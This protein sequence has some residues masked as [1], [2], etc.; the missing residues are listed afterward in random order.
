V[1]C[2]ILKQVAELVRPRV[3]ALVDAEDLVAVAPQA[4]REVRADLPRGAGDQDS[5]AADSVPA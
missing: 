1:P 5:H 3:L 4:E 2:E